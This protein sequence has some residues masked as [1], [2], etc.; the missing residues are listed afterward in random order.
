MRNKIMSVLT[1]MA[2]LPCK[3]AV[4]SSGVP[5]A[6]LQKSSPS[7]TEVW[8]WT[9][10][11]L[12]PLE[13]W[14]LFSNFHILK[15]FFKGAKPFLHS[16]LDS[17]HYRNCFELK[18]RHIISTSM[19][20]RTYYSENPTK[21]PSQFLNISCCFI[22]SSVFNMN[23]PRITTTD[24]NLGFYIIFAFQNPIYSQAFYEVFKPC[25]KLFSMWFLSGMFSH[26]KE[27]TFLQNCFYYSWRKK[28]TQFVF[29]F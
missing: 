3:C 6:A 24:E 29:F 20:Y 8:V 9:E 17:Y 13:V 14:S 15:W 23:L 21:F 12:Q 2:L 1:A 27:L 11:T 4:L 7:Y 22:C 10:R 5:P 18:W 19:E 16:S 26:K 25:L 28:I